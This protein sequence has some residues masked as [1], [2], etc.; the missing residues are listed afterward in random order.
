MVVGIEVGKLSKTLAQFVEGI[1]VVEGEVGEARCSGVG[2]LKCRERV[3]L[4]LE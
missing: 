3:E 2:D 4:R 1:V